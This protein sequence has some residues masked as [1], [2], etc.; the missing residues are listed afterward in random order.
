MLHLNVNHL[1]IFHLERVVPQG[2]LQVHHQV[3]TI[4]GEIGV[5]HSTIALH[6]D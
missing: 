5:V 4:E 1:T 2:M 3:G 6:H